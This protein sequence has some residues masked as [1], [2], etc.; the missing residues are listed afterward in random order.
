MEQT[1]RHYHAFISYRH[2]D[3]D[4]KIA[5]ALQ[6][7]LEKYKI[8]N[9]QTGKMEWL[10]VF[11]DRS[12]LPTSADLGRDIQNALESSDYLV[13]LCSREYQKSAWCMREL[14]YFK[15]LH[16][17]SNER[18]LP[19]LIDGEPDEC[20]PPEICFREEPDGTDASRTLRIPVEP[21]AADVRGDT[22]NRQLK[23]LRSTE[24]LRIA[25]PI[26][27]VPFDTLYQRKTR[28]HIRNLVAVFAVILS[29]SVGFGIYNSAV[30][31]KLTQQQQEILTS[32]AKNLT[33]TAQLLF[34]NNRRK[35]AL[36]TLL[37][38][39]PTKEQ[40]RPAVA[41]AEQTLHELMYTYREP[42][43]YANAEYQGYD[44]II[45]PVLS[46]DGRFLVAIDSSKSLV[47]YDFWAQEEIWRRPLDQSSYQL[48]VCPNLQLIA[49]NNAVLL[50]QPYDVQKI[51]I[52]TGSVEWTVEMPGTYKSDYQFT[53]DFNPILSP[54]GKHLAVCN[55]EE[56]ADPE[57]GTV[58]RVYFYDTQT[59][60]K[61]IAATGITYVPGSQFPQ[62]SAYQKFKLGPSG[63]SQDGRFFTL[64]V[65]HDP[66]EACDSDYAELAVIDLE[67]AC[68]SGFYLAQAGTNTTRFG[69]SGNQYMDLFPLSDPSGASCGFLYRIKAVW[70]DRDPSSAWPTTFADHTLYSGTVFPEAKETPFQA[71]YNSLYAF[72]AIYGDGV[73]VFPQGNDILFVDNTGAERVDLLTLSATS[74]SFADRTCIRCFSEDDRVLL[75]FDNGALGEITSSTSICRPVQADKVTNQICR[76]ATEPVNGFMAIIPEYSSQSAVVC[77]RLGDPTGTSVLSKAFETTISYAQTLPL[78]E[79]N[80]FLL[81]SGAQLS[82]TTVDTQNLIIRTQCVNPISNTNMDFQGINTDKN[83][84]LLGSYI[85]DL[86]ANTIVDSSEF[87]WQTQNLDGLSFL[88]LGDQIL[89]PGYSSALNHASTLQWWHHGVPVEVPLEYQGDSII[90]NRVFSMATYQEDAFLIGANDLL[91]AKMGFGELDPAKEI[92][93]LPGNGRYSGVLIFSLRDQVWRYVPSGA[94]SYYPRD[95]FVPYCAFANSHQQLGILEQDGVLRVYDW[96]RDAYIAQCDLQI[97]YS[98]VR[99]MAFVKNDQYVLI[100]TDKR[101]LVVDLETGTTVFTETVSG[102]D[103]GFT[104]SDRLS[105]SAAEFG[106][107]LSVAL[108]NPLAEGLCINTETWQVEYRIPG[109]RYMDEFAVITATP[110]EKQ[111]ILYPRWST[112]DL[113]AAAAQELS[114]T[115]K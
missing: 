7:K 34:Q 82:A 75:L 30:N 109:L 28:E 46:E 83:L 78:S 26:L 42:G 41:E 2:N 56:S 38:A 87:P 39:F 112:E 57:G 88:A 66:S 48:M 24:C 76:Y 81:T 103:S 92:Y 96:D 110:D 11:R 73:G 107:H 33:F 77:S 9:P 79:G 106:N 99:Y 114:K 55:G 25:A 100:C 105:Y 84:V 51:S 68:F 37:G 35:D 18:I 65:D 49:G 12:E 94:T 86:S 3:R 67:K 44:E 27:G 4:Q 6:K 64:V 17:G 69:G 115:A 85:W 36:Q 102:N 108:D 31:Q 62:N 54:D 95:Y 90:D 32:D 13:I 59:G 50:T 70:E 20:F 93:A 63:F 52:A 60:E 91:V 19:I 29:L 45:R 74:I 22:L 16:G 21:M 58:F 71:R 72:E 111:L 47:C 98:S 113:I 43:Y 104:V 14:T 89:K 97:S 5:A 23:K 40:P 15:A 53:S 8:Q 10:T 101:V 80:A 61:C 1:S